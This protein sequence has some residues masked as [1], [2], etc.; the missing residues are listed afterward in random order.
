MTFPLATCADT[1]C[2]HLRG[3]KMA[4]R[5]IRACRL[6]GSAI[7]LLLI[8]SAWG[9]PAA[10][11]GFYLSQQSARSVGRAFAGQ[12]AGAD[13]AATVVA[14]PAGMTNLGSAQAMAGTAVIFPETKFRNKGSTA[15]TPGTL[16]ASVAYGG[17]NG[18]NP[19]DPAIVPDLYAAVPLFDTS[20]WF[21]VG[22]TSPFGLS[23]DYGSGWFGRYDSVE[24]S[25]TTLELA[26]AI[27]YRLSDGI[28]IGAGLN[29]Q[30]VDVRLTNA[31]PDTLAPGAPSVATD[32][33]NRLQGDDVSVGFNVGLLVSPWPSTRIGAHYRSAIN[34]DLDGDVRVSG[35]GGALAAA[36]GR[37]D[38]DAKLRLP[39]IVC[40]GVAQGIGERAT[41]FA[42]VQW[43]NWSRF[44]EV[45]VKLANA[46]QDAVLPQDYSDSYAVS[47]G[48]EYA[49]RD[50]LTVRGGFRF[51]TTPTSD[52]YRSTGVPEGRNY[53]V[54]AG[55]SY[56]PLRDLDID[57]SLFHT[58]WERAN[59]S[60]TR[61]FFAGTPAAA[62]VDVKGR[63]ET[64][65]TTAALGV[66]YRF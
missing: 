10:A 48:G 32:G 36:N 55:V 66:R 7:F 25:L 31:I 40:V 53:S 62:S 47:V 33:R 38:A 27:A 59:V 61:E 54:G 15:A 29:V 26:P 1:A 19:F 51:E 12:A 37:F 41:V 42:D 21:G 64:S 11:S 43:F 8:A 56:R 60:L 16:G 49:W 6:V 4:P 14:N 24:S 35:L 9:G 5:R 50:D 20:L 45:R 44:N 39:D 13:D 22:L 28:S 52:R 46:S 63:A 17:D 34:H 3:N 30:T 2:R 65:S 58:R 23:L 57:V 18:G